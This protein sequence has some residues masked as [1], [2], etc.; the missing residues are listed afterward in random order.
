MSETHQS[1]KTRLSHGSRLLKLPLV[2]PRGK[3]QPDY[4]RDRLLLLL[5]TMNLRDIWLPASPNIGNTLYG[6]S[7]QLN[8]TAQFYM[9]AMSQRAKAQEQAGSRQ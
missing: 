8:N 5:M 4:R 2:L 9:L 3:P 7:D 1:T 6:E